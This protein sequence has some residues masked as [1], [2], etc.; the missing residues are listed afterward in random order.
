MGKALLEYYAAL[1]LV[2]LNS[3]T[4]PSFSKTGTCTI[5]DLTFVNA[6]LDSGSS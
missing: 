3:G 1:D 2:L 5:I 6:G 4:K